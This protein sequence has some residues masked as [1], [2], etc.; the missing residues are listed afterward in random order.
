MHESTDADRNSAGG[1]PSSP[2]IVRTQRQGGYRSR[3]KPELLRVQRI[4][5]S[6]QEFPASRGD[7][8]LSTRNLK[9]R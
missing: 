5:A 8:A 7:N 3:K 9:S 2:T 1:R 4:E 6:R